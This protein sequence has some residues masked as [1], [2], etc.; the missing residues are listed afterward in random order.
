MFKSYPL[1]MP[2]PATVIAHHSC[3]TGSGWP[4]LERLYEWW[5]VVYRGGVAGRFREEA[6]FYRD[7]RLLEGLLRYDYDV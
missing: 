7:G 3:L 6:L 5:K 4:L 1:V 2:N